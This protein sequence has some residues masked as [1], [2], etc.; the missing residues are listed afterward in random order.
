MSSPVIIV[1]ESWGPSKCGVVVRGDQVVGVHHGKGCTLGKSSEFVYF[2][3]NDELLH[4][5][6]VQGSKIVKVNGNEVCWEVPGDLITG[7][8]GFKVGFSNKGGEP[9]FEFFKVVNKVSGSN[10]LDRV[11]ESVG[12]G[13][14][15]LVSLIGAGKLRFRRFGNEAVEEVH[16]F[17]VVPKL[18]SEFKA[19]LRQC[20]LNWFIMGDVVR[21]LV[22]DPMLEYM[23]SMIYPLEGSRATALHVRITT[24]Y[25]LWVLSQLIKAL[26]INGAKPSNDGGDEVRIWGPGLYLPA[27]TFEFHGKCIHVL[28]QVDV[29]TH[30][31][32]SINLNSPCIPSWLSEC[33]SRCGDEVIHTRPDIMLMMV[34]CGEEVSLTCSDTFMK[35]YTWKYFDRIPLIIEVKLGI[36]EAAGEDII[37]EYETLDTAIKQACMYKCLL[38][39]K[40]RMIIVTYDYV[41]RN[42]KDKLVREGVEVIEGLRPENEIATNEFANKIR[43]ALKSF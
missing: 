21:S 4:T 29:V 34:N 1:C 2:I 12:M 37:R 16:Y 7:K 25:E 11:V 33:L 39:D 36:S 30:M 42:V 8:V 28:Y 22:E 9:L 6:Q 41:G 31:V 35:P 20:G 15:E 3:I 10:E 14:N 5:S 40:P 26:R 43:D 24:S 17:D 19:N 23:H 27:I 38:R 32:K 18:I 13:I